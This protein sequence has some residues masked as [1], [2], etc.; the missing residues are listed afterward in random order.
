MA[1]RGWPGVC[2]PLRVVGEI[3]SSSLGKRFTRVEKTSAVSLSMSRRVGGG[4]DDEAP[5]F[6]KVLRAASPNARTCQII[7]ISIR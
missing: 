4:P 2:G 3:I 7:S 1:S 6:C 5:D